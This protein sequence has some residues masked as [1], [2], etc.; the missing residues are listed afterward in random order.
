[1]FFVPR[2]PTKKLFSLL[3][4]YFLQAIYLTCNGKECLKLRLFVA[5]IIWL[6]KTRVI[7]IPLFTDTKY[8][9]L[10]VQVLIAS[11]LVTSSLHTFSCNA[12]HTY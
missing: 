10:Q 11:T 12:H 5:K 7:P 8:K 4:C 6:L 2:T 3:I 1:M 9:Y